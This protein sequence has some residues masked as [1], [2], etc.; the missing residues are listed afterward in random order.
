MGFIQAFKGAVGSTL[1]DQWRDFY[2]PG[3]DV[4]PT[5]G[6]FPGVPMGTNNG[7]GSNTRG[8]ANIITNGSKVIVPEGTVLVTMQDGAIT[9]L[10]TE[11]GGYQYT[12]DDPNAKSIFSGDGPMDSLIKQSWERFKFGG[13]PGSQQLLFYVNTREIPNNKF[14]TQ[15]EIYWDDAYLGTQVGAVTRGT[16]TLRIVDPILFIKNFVP[17][18]YLVAGA[19]DFDF[20]DMDNPAGEQLFNEVVGSLSAAFSNYTNDPSKGNRMSRI[21]G[22]QIGFATSLSAAVESAYQWRSSRGLEIVKTAILSIEYDEGTRALLEDVKKADALA[23]ARGNSFFQQSAARGVQAAG[24]SGGGSGLAFMGMGMGAVG[25]MSQGMQQPY[26]Q[27]SYQPNFGQQPQPQQPAPQGQPMG[28]MPQQQPYTQGSYQSDFGQQPQPQQQQPTPQ[29]QPMGAMPQ[30]QPV[31]PQQPAPQGQ[32]AEDPTTKL[33]N[34]KKLLDAGVVTQE[35]FD[36]L[37]HDLLGF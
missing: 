7:R 16:Y 30:Q 10:I 12:S 14:G 5:A 24:E 15:S 35:E 31:A 25:G 29:G 33:L 2:G 32:G 34:M 11:V 18:S 22:D 37:K 23:G 21:Q 26:T 13:I 36:R 17:V 27:G 3:Q 6:V 20:A 9:G 19:P 1:G 8:S 4:S 28:A